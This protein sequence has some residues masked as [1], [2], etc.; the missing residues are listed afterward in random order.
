MVFKASILLGLLFQLASSVV[1]AATLESN[2]SAALQKKDWPEL[3]AILKPIQGQN[4]EHDLTLGKALLYLERRPEALALAIKLYGSR[5]DERARSFL[6]LAGTIFFNQE[7]SSL[8]YEGIRLI[9]ILKFTEA[10]ER[11]ELALGK[12]PGQIL[13]ITRLVQV[14]IAL[15]LKDAASQHLKLA[16]EGAPYSQELRLFGAKLA[17][18]SEDQDMDWGREFTPLKSLMM[19]NQVTATFWYESLKRSKKT[20]EL[21]SL[22]EGLLRQHPSWTY[23]LVWFYKKGELT[24][25]LKTKIKTQVEKNLKDKEAFSA[26]LEK[27]MKQSQYI[28]VGF[29]NYELL[30][31]DLK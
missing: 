4:F 1:S 20:N 2:V 11:L 12:E 23:A 6:E 21:S 22:A 13:V 29:I 26:A 3:V 27:E 14:E 18:E 31:N 15:G 17:L 25:K 19:Q 9:S 10:K 24:T 28:W 8:Y 5:K 16:Q 30:L 7:T